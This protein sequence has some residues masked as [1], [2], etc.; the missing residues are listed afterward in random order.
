M[1][2]IYQI[3]MIAAFVLLSGAVMSQGIVKGVIRDATTN[4]ALLGAS[5]AIE[6]T[7]M[8]TTAG[9]DGSFHFSAPAGTHNLLIRFVGYEEMTMQVTVK[10]GQTTDLG[11]LQVKSTAIG[12]DEVNVIANIA[13]GRETPVAVSTITAKNIQDNLGSQEFPEI[14]NYTPNVY[15]TKGSGGYG[16]SKINV[17]GFDQRNI[18][19]M[20]NGIP[21]ND[22]EN[23]WVYWS[24]WAG[25]G[26]ATRSI[27]IQRGLGASKLAINSV[28]GTINIVTKT[29]DMKKGGSLEVG[30]TDFGR[31]K[32]MLS[33]STGKLKTGTAITFVGSKTSGKGYIDATWVDAWSYFLSISQDI[34][35]KHQLV[36]TL[37]GAPQ[38]HGQRD[39]FYMLDSNK[40]DKYGAKYN[41]NWGYRGGEVLNERVNFYHKPQFSINW[42]YDI[43]EKFFLATSYYVSFG[44]GGGSGPLGIGEYMTGDAGSGYFK[45]EPP[46]TASGQYDW[47]LM[48]DINASDMYD[49]DSVLYEAGESKHIIRNSV[50]NHFWTGIISNL[51]WNISDN[52]KFTGGID[53]RIYIGEHYREV[54]DLIGGDYWSDRT[55]GQT[56]VG[57]K[58]AYWNDGIV[59]YSGIF[60]QMEY[61][62]GRFAAFLG[63]T[64]SNTW[65]KRVDYMSYQSGIVTEEYAKDNANISETLSNLGYNAKAG[66]NF[67]I[68]EHNNIFINGGMYSRVPFF[69]FHFLNYKNDVNP[70]LQNEKIYAAELGYGLVLRKFRLNFNAYYSVWDDISQ[71]ASFQT[72]NDDQVNAFISDLKETHMGIELD[73]Q[74]NITHWVSVGGLFAMGDWKYANDPIADLYDDQTQEKIGEGTLYLKDLK[75]YDQP[76]TQVGVNADFKI[77]KTIDIGGQLLYYDNLYSRYT[78]EA[79][80]N[81]DDRGQ[82]WKVPGFA[83]VNARIG[84]AFKIGKLDSYLQ[85]NCYNLFDN[86][87]IIEAEDKTTEIENEAGDVTGYNH[88]FGKGFWGFGRN[89]NFSFRINF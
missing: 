82:S 37:I 47:D 25:L 67:N 29:T 73:A 75:V 52:F 66:A 53:G 11:E 32:T 18:A 78:L 54:R 35:K 56:T 69:R 55:F 16:D 15:A 81:P 14:M 17:R 44:T 77:A 36:F 41:Q 4:E 60:A 45:Y 20:I 49:G 80:T 50:N 72:E 7:T 31:F 39:G 1:R 6:G 46:Q 34:G 30:V 63:G 88:S 48:A 40:F 28:G 74:Y 70:N 38:K 85:A 43:N 33:L 57:D 86:S 9:L 26:D 42:Y 19:V 2:K 71:L 27:Q 51:T 76:Q 58:I 12:L 10:E 8:G 23:G 5:A 84:W 87:Y 65:T 89:F 79:R 22:M 62:S 59:Q 68:D 64:V 61:T 3:L 83:T 21:V 24:N 13:V